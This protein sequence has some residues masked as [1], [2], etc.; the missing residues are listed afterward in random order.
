MLSPTKI[1][2]CGESKQEM[3]KECISIESISEEKCNSVVCTSHHFL[4]VPEA[5]GDRYRFSNYV[6]DPNKF[7]FRKVVRVLG[8]VLLFI[9]KL[10]EKTNKPEFSITTVYAEDLPGGIVKPAHEDRFLVTSGRDADSR[11]VWTT[12][13]FQTFTM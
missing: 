10:R 5:V 8:L 6:L 12:R 11:Y 7:R 2:L 3:L 4:S 9:K 1:I 13:L